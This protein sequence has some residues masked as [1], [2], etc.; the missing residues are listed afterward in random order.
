MSDDQSRSKALYE[1]PEVDNEVVCTYRR[2]WKKTTWPQSPST[3]LQRTALF[4]LDEP[5]ALLWSCPTRT[6]DRSLRPTWPRISPW[7]RPNCPR[8]SPEAWISRKEWLIR[9]LTSSKW[10]ASSGYPIRVRKRHPIPVGLQHYIPGGWLQREA[11]WESLVATILRHPKCWPRS[12]R[13]SLKEHQGRGR[14]SD[15]F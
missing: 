9:Q 15:W 13:P 5:H 10:S 4:G 1:R 3:W 6:T 2:E 11:W 14:S 7:R 12:C 8:W